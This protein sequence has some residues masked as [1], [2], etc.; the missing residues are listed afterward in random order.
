MFGGFNG[1]AKVNGTDY[2]SLS[3]FTIYHAGEGL[4]SD[5]IFSQLRDHTGILWLGTA[6][7]I[8]YYNGVSFHEFTQQGLGDSI[9]DIVEDTAYNLWFASNHGVGKY[10][11][12]SWTYYYKS[13]G[14]SD[15][16]VHEMLFDSKGRMWFATNNGLSMLDTIG[17][18]VFHKTDGL[19]YDRTLCLEEDHS[20]NIWVGTNY[21]VT[22][23]VFPQDTTINIKPVVSG[24]K[25]FIFDI[26]PNPSTGNFTIRTDQN[27]NV[28]IYNSTGSIVY[29]RQINSFG[30][31]QFDLTKHQAG[32]Y[33]VKARFGNYVVVK[34][35][36]IM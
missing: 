32:I 16:E 23:L 4:P 27:P 31:S 11:S 22:E 25:R 2:Y 36:I 30:S 21:G 12:G 19:V 13:D 7:G 6:L 10:S 5:C 35:L 3:T 28:S 1:L 14:L 15:N 18:T 9:Y 8:S 20:G 17:W 24:T 26:L 34:K 29:T 33:F